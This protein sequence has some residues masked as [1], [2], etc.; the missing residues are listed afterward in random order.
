MHPTW[1]AKKLKT[2]KMGVFSFL[3]PYLERNP[4]TFPANPRRMKLLRRQTGAPP[5]LANARHPAKK[6]WDVPINLV[7]NK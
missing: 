7:D 3:A 4:N 6:F 5:P 1:G 2:P